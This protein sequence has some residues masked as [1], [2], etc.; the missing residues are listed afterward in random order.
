M[1]GRRVYTQII[2]AL[3]AASLGACA[4]IGFASCAD[5]AEDCHNTLSC[6]PPP[7]CFEAGDA[8]DEIDG[9]N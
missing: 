4:A 5:A 1:Q 8:L 2:G 7:Y 3:M 9:C 6:E